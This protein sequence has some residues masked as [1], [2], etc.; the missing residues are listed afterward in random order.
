MVLVAMIIGRFIILPKLTW[1][2][3]LAATNGQITEEIQAGKCGQVPD[4]IVKLQ[5]QMHGEWLSRRA[6]EE[7]A[8]EPDWVMQNYFLSAGQPD[9]TKITT[10]VGLPLPRSSEYRSGR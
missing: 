5:E 2:A 3:V 1:A 10:I 9:H 6:D 7:L 4:H 8:S